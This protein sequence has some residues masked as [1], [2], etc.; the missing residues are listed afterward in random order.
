MQGDAGD[1]PALVGLVFH[2]VERDHAAPVRTDNPYRL[3][4]QAVGHDRLLE[5][6]GA[7]PVHGREPGP[8]HRHETVGCAEHA[9]DFGAGKG[10]RGRPIVAREGLD[11]AFDHGFEGGALVVGV[12]RDET[13]QQR[14]RGGG[15]MAPNGHVKSIGM[16]RCRCHRDGQG[17]SLYSCSRS[18]ER[19]MPIRKVEPKDA[20][21]PVFPRPQ[22]ADSAAARVFSLSSH[23]RAR[24]ALDFGLHARDPGFNV[25]VVGEDRSGRMTAT[26]D[27]LDG[28]VDGGARPDDWIYL[29][30]FQRENEPLAVRLPAGEGRRFR[31]ALTALVPQ[32]RTALHQAFTREE[33]HQRVA[34]RDAAMREEVGKAIEV[35]RAEAE[36]SGLS[37]VQSPE[38]LMVVPLGEDGKPRDISDLPETERSAME[39]A[40]QRVTQMLGEINRDAAR[41]QASLADEVLELNRN[42]AEN[43][44]SGLID[45]FA[46]RFAEHGSLNR[47]LVA[48]R[49]DVIENLDLFR[50]DG[51][52]GEMPPGMPAP[53]RPTPEARYA[54]N[55]LVDNADVAGPPIVLEPNPT[56]ENLFGRI[57]YRQVGGVLQTDFS[58]V[59]PGS[60]HRANGGVLVLRAEAIAAHADTWGQLKGALRDGA[61]RMQE[62]YRAGGVPVAGAP[63][64]AAVPLDVKVVIVGAPQ[65]YYTFFSVDPEFQAYFKVKAEIDGE[66][67]ADPDNLACYAGLLQGFANKHGATSC[68]G[69]AID[70]LLGY[71]SRLASDRE[72]L[73]ARFELVEDIV[74]EAIYA[75]RDDG[76]KEIDRDAVRAARA[77]RRS[78]NARMEDRVHESIQRG[79]VLISTEGTA[80]GQIN[81]LTVRDPGDHAFGAPSRV[82]ARTSVGRRGVTNIEREV[83]LGGPIQ[84]KGALVIQGFLA[85]LFARRMP[86]SFNASITF[87]QSYGGVEGDSA[88]LA[89]VLAILSDLSGAP[90]RQD[91]AVTGSVNQRGEVQ[92]IG[93]LSHKAEGF[94][95]ACREAG[96]LTGDQGV[97]FPESNAIN[98]VLD[99][100][101]AAAVEAGQFHMYA[102]AHVDAALELFTGVAAGTPDADGNYPADTIYGRVAAQLVEFDRALDE[103]DR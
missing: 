12:R 3:G 11:L 97:V 57:E 2:P 78:R 68:T 69:D 52:G 73:S 48:F 59:Q 65:W 33:Y 15:E 96:E 74:N 80:V 61:I 92:A 50:P 49:V 93:G 34:E 30:N 76:D 71:A 16:I 22:S 88:S 10:K 20:G 25:F 5:T 19:R 42:V 55:L 58:L 81:G 44:V 29:N 7:R 27:Y 95:R 28:A 36:K 37:L 14:E 41:R 35:A 53:P 99:D 9:L 101:V 87:E 79:G 94:F 38:G 62:Q 102:A 90:L 13:Q 103:R 18:E 75:A 66:M 43:A 26:L 1:A 47:W 31:D 84:Q 67:D 72:K 6:V 56:Y 85:G 64:P 21:F 91:L 70:Y 100:D 83:M 39:E 23:A 8:H 32:L 54:V 17:A 98:L 89:E 77:S 86:L 24:E 60:L 45:E 51:G 46:A 82:T 4:W 63:K 40:G